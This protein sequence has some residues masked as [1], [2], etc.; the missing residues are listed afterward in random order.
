MR[1]DIHCSFLS[2]KIFRIASKST[3]NNKN[4]TQFKNRNFQGLNW[5]D[6]AKK[7]IP[8]PFVPNISGELDVSNFAEEFTA[9]VPTD[10]PAVVPPDVDKLFKVSRFFIC[11]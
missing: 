7:K 4:Q 6:L 8:A 3:L 2:V 11:A 5:E 1:V 10:S 9:M